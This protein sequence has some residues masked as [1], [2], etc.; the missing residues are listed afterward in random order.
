MK[1]EVSILHHDYPSQVRDTVEDKLQRLVK[2][3]DRLVSIR[4]LLEKQ[5]DDHRVE[6]VANVGNGNVLVVDARS[7]SFGSAL[8]E[9]TERMTRVL[10]RHK[11][12]Q[13]DA[14]RR[15]GRVGH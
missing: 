5:N 10:T 3:N 14:R 6:F 7:D 11:T 13:T 2:F 1:T 15:G 4:A 12:K 9:A 8:D